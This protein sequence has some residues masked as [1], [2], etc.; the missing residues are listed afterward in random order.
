MVSNEWLRGS[1]WNKPVNPADTDGTEGRRVQEEQAGPPSAPGRV[2]GSVAAS[3]DQ[4]AETAVAGT[5]WSAAVLAAAPDG[6][7]S[8]HRAGKL[9][10]SA[11][12][13]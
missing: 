10:L 8:E 7:A 1:N 3:G 2:D 11:S 4:H 12:L 5:A 6:S 13:V 9:F